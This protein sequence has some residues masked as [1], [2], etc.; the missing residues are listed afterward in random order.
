MSNRITAGPDG[1]GAAGAAA[2]RAAREAEP[3]GARIGPITLR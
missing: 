2:D 1:S 3:R